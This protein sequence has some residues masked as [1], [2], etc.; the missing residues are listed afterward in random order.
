ML[1][2]QLKN[3][4]IGF[5]VGLERDHRADQSDPSLE[6]SLGRSHLIGYTRNPREMTRY[7]LVIYPSDYFCSGV[8]GTQAAEPC[9]PLQDWRGV[10]LLFGQAREEWI[11][12]GKTLVVYADVLAST[13]YLVSRYEEMYRRHERDIHGRF[14]G[15]SSLPYRA[16]FLHRPIVDEYGD[17]LRQ[18]LVEHDML[19][20]R[21]LCLEARPPYFSKINL[22]HDVDQP[23]QYRGLWSYLRAILKQGRNPFVAIGLC[24]GNP[25]R[26]AYNTFAKF[27]EW[28]RSVQRRT[29]QGLTDTIFFL[30]TPA[31]HRLD[32]PNYRLGRPYMRALLATMR[33]AE[34]RFGLHCSYSAGLTPSEILA[35]RQ[36]LQHQLKS[37]IVSSRHHFLALREP[38][39]MLELYSAGI[40]HD[41]TMGYADVAGFRLGTCRP[42][43]FINP[44][45][46]HLTELMLHPLTMMDVSLSRPDYMRLDL[47]QAEAYARGLVE[48]TARY[49]G[50]LNLLWHN[51]QF[52]PKVHPWQGQLYRY[53]LCLIE[54]IERHDPRGAMP[55]AGALKA[56]L[57]LCGGTELHL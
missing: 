24:F 41:Y 37:Q 4:L 44:N 27:I 48:Q 11:N 56:Q 39:D 17:R 51:E 35:Q 9:L 18:L 52:C 43:K 29:P 28:N 21:G 54:D 2:E 6:W 46:R 19:S 16:G 38:E 10:P 1:S 42:V 7:K 8:Y 31:R 50:E 14:P 34:V 20:S 26:D 49:H 5:L 55:E 45:T 15:K 12:D 32:R 23:Y 33:R 30:K 36:L 3:Y 22:T 53:L 13:Y 40:R 57:D 47:E 25:R